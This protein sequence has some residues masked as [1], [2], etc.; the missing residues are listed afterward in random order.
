MFAAISQTLA[1]AGIVAV[2]AFAAF[3]AA[4]VAPL[5]ASAFSIKK[6]SDKASPNFFRNA[7][8]G[9]HYNGTAPAGGYKSPV[10]H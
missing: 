10:K 7:T 4:S 9:G 1:R 5:P 2:L 3:A 6:L 8:A